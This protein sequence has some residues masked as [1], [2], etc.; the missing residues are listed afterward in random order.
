MTLSI[1]AF[2]QLANNIDLDNVH[3]RNTLTLGQFR[4]LTEGSSD[5]L[6]LW[7]SVEGGNSAVRPS[8]KMTVAPRYVLIN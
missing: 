1:P 7:V 8:Q 4:Q 5:D 2:R 3:E 6:V